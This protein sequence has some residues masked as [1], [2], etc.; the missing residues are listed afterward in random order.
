MMFSL[1]TG[2]AFMY[3]FPVDKEKLKY[4]LHETEQLPL[5]HIWPEPPNCP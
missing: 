4:L 5:P 3:A 2:K 1:T